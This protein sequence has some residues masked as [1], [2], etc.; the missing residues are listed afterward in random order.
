[1]NRQL[2]LHSEAV[3]DLPSRHVFALFGSEES[4]SW[5]FSARCD[6]IAVG[7]PVR[8][9]LPMRPHADFTVEIVGR[10]SRLRRQ[11]LIVIEHHQPWR[12]ELRVSFDAVGP[13]RT[14]VRLRAGL[15]AS[16][17][18][19]LVRRIG[20]ALP[21]PQPDDEHRIGVL[22]SKS[23][24][25]VIYAQGIEHMAELAVDEINADGGVAGRRLKVLIA[26]D[27]TQPAEAAHQARRLARASCRAIFA[28]TTSASF[29]AAT[30]AVRSHDILMVQPVINEGGA[31]SATVVRFGERPRAQIAALARPLMT[32][33]HGRRWFL[34]GQQ[35]SWS[36]GA[37]AAAGAVLDDQG[38]AVV[39]QHYVP[40]GTVDF[41]SVIN[42]IQ[43]S[44]TD[45][46]MS[47]LIGADEVAFQRQYAEA[48]LGDSSQILSLVMDEATYDH[49][50]ATA[51]ADIWTALSY[52]EDSG[53]SGNSDLI[54]RYRD[55][56]GRWAPPITALSEIIYEAVLQ[57]ARVLAHAPEA[58]AA[59][60]ARE[61][62]AQRA[63]R[64]SVVGARDLMSQRLYLARSHAGSLRVFDRTD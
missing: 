25:A 40:V 41:T 33:A 62:R 63:G 27:W 51:S 22:T 8:L 4:A 23:G 6:R 24:P 52:F 61:L 21:D 30:E 58:G 59:Y 37:H 18:D 12:G 19:W 14:R 7:A 38:G 5:L 50:G 55:R 3:L 35:Y 60:I 53:E 15:D 45:I 20:L 64:N 56:Y 48:G 29:L 39:G 43:R 10:F 34:V 49:I 57:Y 47:S 26:D 9:S 31:E 16:G 11:S 13:G 46:V 36:Y 42:Q 1:L 17:V 2:T 44:G 28:G 54:A 32:A